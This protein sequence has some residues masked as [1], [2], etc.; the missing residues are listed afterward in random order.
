MWFLTLSLCLLRRDTWPRVS[1]TCCQPL[2]LTHPHCPGSLSP[3]PRWALQLPSRME[4][5]STGIS[6]HPELA[7]PGDLCLLTLSNP[8]FTSCCSSAAPLSQPTHPFCL[9]PPRPPFLPCGLWAPRLTA[10]PPLPARC[11]S[12]PV[13]HGALIGAI[14]NVRA[15]L[16]A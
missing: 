12:I 4:M 2:L 13:A 9:S 16:G 8:A 14:A 10:C 15:Q 5:P 11:S 3:P 7:R 6:H 1:T